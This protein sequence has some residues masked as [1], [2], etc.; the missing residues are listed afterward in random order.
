MGVKRESGNLH[1]ITD[2]GLAR[3]FKK[4][5]YM[6]PGKLKQKLFETYDIEYNAKLG[7]LY[8]HKPILVKDFML[9]RFFAKNMSVKDIRVEPRSALRL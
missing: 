2:R 5:D 6:S 3:R 1:I 9:V 4:G 8:I 7:I